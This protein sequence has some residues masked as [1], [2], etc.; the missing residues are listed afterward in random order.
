MEVMITEAKVGEESFYTGTFRDIIRRKQAE[1]ELYQA[2]EAAEAANRSKSV[3]LA[4]ID[5]VSTGA[6]IQ[7]D[8]PH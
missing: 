2:K 7:C 5:K 6:L 4:N 1:M 8:A 3:F